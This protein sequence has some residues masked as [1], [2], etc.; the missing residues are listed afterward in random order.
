[1]AAA[2]VA[3]KSKYAPIAHPPTEGTVN[4]IPNVKPA[5]GMTF[6]IDSLDDR[7]DSMR[8]AVVRQGY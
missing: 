8:Y 6:D 4:T 2:N 7:V 5:I 1:M 3:T